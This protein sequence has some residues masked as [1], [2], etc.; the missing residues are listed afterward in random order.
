MGHIYIYIFSCFFAY[1]V[2]FDQMPGIYFE[3]YVVGAGVVCIPLNIFVLFFSGKQL[4]YLET[5]LSF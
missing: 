4:S 5:I 3:F 1:F 2:S